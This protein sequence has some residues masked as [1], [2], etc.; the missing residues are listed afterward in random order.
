[1]CPSELADRVHALPGAVG[2]HSDDV[3]GHAISS[4]ENVQ[5]G[6]CATG[7]SF[8]SC[9]DT[10][11]CGGGVDDAI[12]SGDSVHG[13]VVGTHGLEVVFLPF[14]VFICNKEKTWTCAEKLERVLLRARR[15][16]ARNAR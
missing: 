11:V 9:L 16:R 13:V 6:V 15:D 4:D 7:L 8:L 3:P 12:V 14:L 10:A 2:A 5:E 1:M